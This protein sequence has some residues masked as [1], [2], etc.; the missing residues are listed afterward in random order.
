[1]S[2]V[3]TLL[4]QGLLALAILF[5]V[6]LGGHIL[7][8]ASVDDKLQ[9]LTECDAFVHK[10]FEEKQRER[11]GDPYATDQK[12]NLLDEAIERCGDLY[13]KLKAENDVAR[14]RGLREE[15]YRNITLAREGNYF[16]IME[17][18]SSANELME[19]CP[20]LKAEIIDATTDIKSELG[21][22][23]DAER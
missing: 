12:A 7:W 1:M 23:I 4:L 16:A 22:N 10:V 6:G 21:E 3:T 17:L 14:C 13:R 5:G 19:N 9:R 8:E 20:E 15:F 2:R 18:D 11:S